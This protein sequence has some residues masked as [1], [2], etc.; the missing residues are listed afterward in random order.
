[1][2]QSDLP[3]LPEHQRDDVVPGPRIPARYGSYSTSLRRSTREW[4]VLERGDPLTWS[5]RWR[6]VDDYTDADCLVGKYARSG[7]LQGVVAYAKDEGAILEI[8]GYPVRPEDLTVIENAVHLN[9]FQRALRLYDTA[10]GRA[11]DV[12]A[13]L[14]KAR[15]YREEQVKRIRSTGGALRASLLREFGWTEADLEIE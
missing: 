9:D 5:G 11:A 4:R 13:V 6:S 3:L 7:A 14:E 12:A 2:S 8:D 1:M 10:G 15:L